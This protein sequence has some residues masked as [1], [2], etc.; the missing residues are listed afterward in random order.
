LTSLAVLDTVNAFLNDYPYH[1]GLVY[2]TEVWSVRSAIMSGVKSRARV[3]A[4]QYSCARVQVGA[5]ESKS[6]QQLDRC[7]AAAV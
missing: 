3:A 4:A 1:V 2:R 7:L 6:R 5:L